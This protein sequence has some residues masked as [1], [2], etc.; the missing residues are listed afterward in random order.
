MLLMTNVRTG[1]ISLTRV[2]GTVSQ[3]G[4]FDDSLNI[5]ISTFCVCAVCLPGFSKAFHFPLQLLSF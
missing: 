5:L 4:N 2:K 1:N 3:D